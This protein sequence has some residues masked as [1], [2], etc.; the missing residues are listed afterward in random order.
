[1]NSGEAAEEHEIPFG[2]YVFVYRIS[3]DTVLDTRTWSSAGQA[4]LQIT[5]FCLFLYDFR[6]ALKV[7]R[8][9]MG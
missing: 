1:V 6:L 5:T 9:L 7:T 8:L 2:E 4:D 3:K